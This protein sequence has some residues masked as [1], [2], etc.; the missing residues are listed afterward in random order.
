MCCP[1]AT[2]AVWSCAWLHGA[3]ASDDLLDALRAWGEAHEFAAGDENAADLLGLPLDGSVPGSAVTVLGALRAGGINSA[4]LVLPVA[5]DVRGLGGGGALTDLALRAGEAV[6]FTASTPG[7][8]GIVPHTVTEGLVRWQAHLVG[9]HTLPEHVGL[10]DAEHALTDAVRDSGSALRA[11]DVARERAGVRDELAGKLR[12]APRLDWPRGTPPRALRV[13]QRA[14][15]V[16]AILEMA[17]ADEPGGAVSASAATRRADALRP[18]HAAVRGARC[19][20]VDES[21][22]VLTEQTDR[23]A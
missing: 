20:A 11:M 5:G 7:V 2:L 14:Q 19:A 21:V 10:A 1:S 8:L 17:G 9:T 3:A 16:S 12:A 15:E 13:L 22:R 23:Q 6:L 18:L 4:R